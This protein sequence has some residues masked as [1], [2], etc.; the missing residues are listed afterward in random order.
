MSHEIMYEENR[1][2]E[3]FWLSNIAENKENVELICNEARKVYESNKN[4]IKIPSLYYCILSKLLVFK[5]NDEELS[6]ERNNILKNN[7]GEENYYGYKFYNLYFYNTPQE[8]ED[9][10]ELHKEAKEIFGECKNEQTTLYYVLILEKVSLVPDEE[11]RKI[12]LDEIKKICCEKLNNNNI[13]YGIF[14]RDFLFERSKYQTENEREETLN[15]VT[16]IHQIIYKK[17]MQN[18]LVR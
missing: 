12:V 1:M 14:L 16:Q 11:Y 5:P 10:L 9:F 2:L 4:S 18:Q 7:M 6:A 17:Y 3:L 13:M 15:E 8:K